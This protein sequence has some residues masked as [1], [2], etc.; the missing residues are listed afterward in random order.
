MEIVSVR[1][2]LCHKQVITPDGEVVVTQEGYLTEYDDGFKIWH[3]K[4]KTS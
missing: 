2:C 3:Q 4:E 1:A